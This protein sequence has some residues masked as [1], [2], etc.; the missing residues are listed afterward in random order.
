M[1]NIYAVGPDEKV[2]EGCRAVETL[3]VVWDLA[4]QFENLQG[5]RDCVQKEV[6]FSDLFQ[7][8]LTAPNP[9]R[10]EV[11]VQTGMRENSPIEVAVERYIREHGATGV[12][13]AIEGLIYDLF[14]P[15]TQ[16]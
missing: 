2:A 11:R 6:V 14:P 12:R 1:P 8:Q 5:A 3:R 9:M 4:N 10:C 16:A 7:Q 15:Q 13:H